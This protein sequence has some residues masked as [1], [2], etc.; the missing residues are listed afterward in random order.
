MP[1]L[2]IFYFSK[3]KYEHM[4]DP[5]EIDYEVQSSCL[6]LKLEYFEE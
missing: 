2:V 4:T 6:K 3:S 1:Q 5:D